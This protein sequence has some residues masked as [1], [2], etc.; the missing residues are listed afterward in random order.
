MPKGTWERPLAGR[1][2]GWRR[3]EPPAPATSTPARSA[4]TGR[5]RGCAA[6]STRRSAAA[7]AR[8]ARG[9]GRP[10]GRHARGARPGRGARALDRRRGGWR[11]PDDGRRVVRPAARCRGGGRVAVPAPATPARTPRARRAGAP[12]ETSVR[13]L[14]RPWSGSGVS[15]SQPRSTG[16]SCC[17]SLDERVEPPSQLP[18]RLSRAVGLPEPERLQATLRRRHAPASAVDQRPVSAAKT[19]SSG[20]KKSRSWIARAEAW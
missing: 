19:S 10:Q 8:L 17:M 20:R 9:P 5:R 1:R 2:R 18:Q 12:T 7:P 11:S 13:R 15:E 14:S 6:S 4:A 3:R 16:R